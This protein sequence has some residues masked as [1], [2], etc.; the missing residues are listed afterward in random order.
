MN[1]PFDYT[2]DAACEQAFRE[3][4]VKIESLKKK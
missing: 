1:N 3:L 2:P 4:I